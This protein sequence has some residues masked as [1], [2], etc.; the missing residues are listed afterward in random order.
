MW[1]LILMTFGVEPVVSFPSSK[2]IGSWALPYPKIK[3]TYY[4][5][6]LSPLSFMITLSKSSHQKNCFFLKLLKYPRMATCLIWS[7]VI[8][9][10]A[11]WQFFGSI[12]SRVGMELTSSVG[13]LTPLQKMVGLEGSDPASYWV[14]LVAFQGLFV[15]NFGGVVKIH[16]DVVIYFVAWCLKCHTQRDTIT[17]ITWACCLHVCLFL[18]A[19]EVSFSVRIS[20]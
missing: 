8:R 2:C 6:L 15:L 16:C 1:R 13:W 9:R 11:W 3:K 19:M 17:W 4:H 10:H 7:T 5:T 12:G 14:F 18:Q 20:T